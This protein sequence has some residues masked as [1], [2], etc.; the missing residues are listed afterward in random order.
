MLPNNQR[1]TEGIKEEI[2][3]IPRDKW[4]WKY[5]DPK[6]TGLS[7]S[8]SKREVFSKLSLPQEKEKFHI[9]NLTLH[10]MEL[11]KEKNSQS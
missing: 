4:K 11:Q 1:I 9:N 8:S 3:K 7:K 5:N 10:L 2:K 6:P